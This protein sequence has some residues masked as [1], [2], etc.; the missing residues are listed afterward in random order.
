MGHKNYAYINK[1]MLVWAR[2]QTPFKDSIDYL[3]E[4]FPRI[5]KDELLKWERGEEL[6]S[7]SEAK[8]L[9]KI[10]K[11]P[12]AC[13]YLTKVPEK[14][15]KKY[16]DRRTF[17]DI[18]KYELSYEL[19]SEIKRI[20]F[21]R[22]LVLFYSEKQETIKNKISQL[23]SEDIE[24]TARKIREYIGMP[25]FY[26]TK[27]GPPFKYFRG[28]IENKNIL[29][30]QIGDVDLK[31][32]K[33]LS[34]C[35]N[36][37]PIIAVNNKDYERAKVFSLFHELAHLVRRSSSLCL[38]DDNERN[39]DEEKICDRLAAEVLM[40]K[41]Q[42]S[43]LAD[44]LFKSY[45]EWNKES[46][47]KLGKKFGVSMVAA[48][49]RLYN[50]NYFSSEFYYKKYKEIND[51]FDKIVEDDKVKI[52]GQNIPFDYYIKY[53]NKHGYLMPRT[54]LNAFNLGKISFGEV[55]QALDIKKNHIDD[56]S[57]TV[58]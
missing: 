52:K 33:G 58:L 46:L 13:L 42:F 1:E 7:I 35:E 21:D 18:K 34:V 8:D 16:V 25:D 56:I 36:I 24:T 54:V 22:E 2:N 3:V 9:C 39:D 27:F 23:L 38:I 19:W 31:E 4:R 10:Y 57:R 32:M 11:V 43:L 55:C 37:F 45:K 47:F 44:K 14:E 50:L 15:P 17:A 49:R 5:R 40:P 12:F 41:E 51:D 48:F 28:L 53:I 30:T 20:K 26:K 29:V 6:P